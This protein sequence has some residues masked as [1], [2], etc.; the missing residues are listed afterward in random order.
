MTELVRS[1]RAFPRASLAATY[2]RGYPV[3]LEAKAEER[4]SLA[5]T[6]E[7]GGKKRNYLPIESSLRLNSHSIKLNTVNLKHTLHT[8][9]RNS[10]QQVKTEIPLLDILPRTQNQHNS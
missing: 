7:N 4:D 6:W 2:A 3:A 5:L 10:T 1:G 8:Q 9:E